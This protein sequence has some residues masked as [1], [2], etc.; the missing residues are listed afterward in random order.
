MID[1]IYNKKFNAQRGAVRQGLGSECIVAIEGGFIVKPP[2]PQPIP[3][4][5]PLIIRGKRA[6]L[7]AVLRDD[8]QPMPTLVEQ[9][10]WQAH[11]LRAAMCRL[12]KDGP[13]K[14]E[15]R[16]VEGVTQY[17]AEQAS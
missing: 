6:R 15:R 2:E 11:T 4:T 13:V 8:W 3:A 14:I 16:R 10:G 12:A 7:L 1:K 9:F 5:G 17:R